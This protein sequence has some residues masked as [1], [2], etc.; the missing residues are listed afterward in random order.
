MLKNPLTDLAC[1]KVGSTGWVSYPGDDHFDMSIFWFE[2]L[3][4]RIR[5]YICIYTC[6]MCLVLFVEYDKIASSSSQGKI[7]TPQL[8]KIKCFSKWNRTDLQ[9]EIVDFFLGETCT[10]LSF[11]DVTQCV[12]PVMKESFRF[13]KHF[14][15]RKAYQIEDILGKQSDVFI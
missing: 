15:K 14:S 7:P 6:A 9:M 10:C 5:E 12:V 8:F 13:E 11:P 3:Q 2:R 1:G 4:G